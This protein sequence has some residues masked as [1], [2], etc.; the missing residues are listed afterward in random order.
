MDNYGGCGRMRLRFSIL[1]LDVSDEGLNIEI[2]ECP[3]L[4]GMKKNPV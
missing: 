4:D 3:T 2:E 1:H